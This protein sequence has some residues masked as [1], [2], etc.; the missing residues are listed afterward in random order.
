MNYKRLVSGLLLLPV[1]GLAQKRV[2]D[3]TLLYNSVI[4]NTQDAAKKIFPPPRTQ[5]HAD[6]AS[7]STTKL[8]QY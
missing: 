5:P 7:L 4:T 6:T 3:L 2:G 8:T 1:L